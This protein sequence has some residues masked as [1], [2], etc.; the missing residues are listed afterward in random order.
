VAISFEDAKYA[1]M[2]DIYVKE[3]AVCRIIFGITSVKLSEKARK[4]LKDIL[5]L[6]ERS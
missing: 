4:E 6:S 2:C 5:L 3:E 1:D